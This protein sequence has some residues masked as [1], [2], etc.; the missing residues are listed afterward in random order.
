MPRLLYSLLFTVLMPFVLL[1]L[2][3][4]IRTAPIYAKRW[5]Q[6]FGVFHAPVG[7][8]PHTA[9]WFHTVSVGEFIAAV[10]LIE[11]VLHAHPQQLLVITTTTPT[12]S[13]QV[14][15]RFAEQ[16]ASGQVFH[17]Y[18]PY[19]LPWLLTG[20]LRKIKP[21]LLVILETELW[22]NL[23][24]C[25]KKAG[26]KVMLVNGRLSEKSAKGYAKV[27][28]LSRGMLANIDC[29]AVQNA[30]DG[31]RFLTLGLPPASMQVTGSIKFDIEVSP[32]IL[33]QGKT[34]RAGF[35]EQR[36][37]CIMASTHE[38]EDEVGLAAFAQLL[39]QDPAA[40]LILVPRHPE[41][42]DK[43]AKL[44]QGQSLS[45]AR[46]SSGET[47][48]QSTQVLLVD[49]M[50]ELMQFLAASDVC[51]MGGSFVENGGHNPLEPAVLALPI[52]MGPSQFNFALICQML[53]QAGGLQ[54]V[55]ADTLAEQLMHFQQDSAHRLTC[56]QAAMAVVEANRGAKQKVFELI[57]QQLS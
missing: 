48:G 33:Q 22:P 32:T 19:D 11:Q 56:G 2:L 3:M 47:V 52:L 53:E 42:F 46:R 40:L 37:V 20:F 14:K 1:R 17:V 21:K 26:C 36:F 43:V 5:W 6:R 13:E 29:L 10:P 15:K 30:M 49:T 41:R 44:V 39:T 34:H 38:S 25:S 4:R 16:L 7:N 51:I 35:G 54:T 50:G 45:L 18:L 31:E 55:S 24:H 28:G 12:G 27:A 9:I 8:A 57:E 23:I